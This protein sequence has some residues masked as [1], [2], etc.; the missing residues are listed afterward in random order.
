MLDHDIYLTQTETETYD[1]LAIS[2]G[3]DFQ[4][5]AIETAWELFC[6]DIEA[7]PNYFSL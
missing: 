3:M 2:L 4:R 5:D 7:D 1:T 6:A